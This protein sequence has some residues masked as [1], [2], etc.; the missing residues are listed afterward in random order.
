M[1]IEVWQGDYCGRE[2]V[3]F[4]SRNSE[5]DGEVIVGTGVLD[6]LGRDVEGSRKVIG[7]FLDLITTQKLLN[8]DISF[9]LQALNNK[10]VPIQLMDLVFSLSM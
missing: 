8:Q 3:W 7:S 1:E 10:Q 4:G 2:D 6:L 5:E 9:P